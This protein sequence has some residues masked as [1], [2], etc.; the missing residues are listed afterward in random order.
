M[1]QY[2]IWSKKRTQGDVMWWRP[3][4]TGYTRDFKKA[5]FY[6]EDEARR[7]CKS[8]TSVAIS[9]TDAMLMLKMETVC[10]TSAGNNESVLAFLETRGRE[11]LAATK[12]VET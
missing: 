12:E 2:L 1:Q 9:A 5:G 4:S 7:I 8:G 3:D 10:D 6:N 11:R